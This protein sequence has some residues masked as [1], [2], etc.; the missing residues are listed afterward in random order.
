[1]WAEPVPDPTGWWEMTRSAV[2]AA[3]GAACAVILAAP[4][5]GAPVDQIWAGGF[6]HDVTHLGGDMESGSQDFL[7]EIDSRRPRLLR[8]LGAPRVGLA[9]AVN[10]AGKSSFASLSLVWDRRL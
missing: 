5:R 4:A 1:M 10:S 6:A 3:A 2:S 9:V 7:L 8:P